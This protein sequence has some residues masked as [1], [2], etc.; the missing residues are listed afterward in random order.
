MFCF[1]FLFLGLFEYPAVFLLFIY[2]FIFKIYFTSFLFFLA[3]SGLSCGMWAL[4]CGA[5]APERVLSV[6]CGM[7]AQLEAC[8]LSSCGAQA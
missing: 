7:Q 5:W 6:V 2:L 3:A 4:H 8:G 1:F